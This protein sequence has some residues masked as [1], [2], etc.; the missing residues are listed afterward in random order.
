[1]LGS[2]PDVMIRGAR[3][4]RPKPPELQWSAVIVSD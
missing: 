3:E 4:G 1:M 2:M